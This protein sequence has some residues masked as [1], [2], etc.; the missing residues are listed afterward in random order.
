M[1][2]VNSLS[3]EVRARIVAALVEGVSISSIVRMTGVAK[4]TILR[5][6]REVG[7]ACAQFHDE[8]VRNLA[9]E[10][11]QADE[12]WS[13]CAMK[14]KNVP[15]EL[16][17]TIGIGSI[18]TWT[19][20]DADSRLIISWLASNRSPEAANA[21]LHDL[22]SR[23]SKHLQIS[24]DGLPHY[25]DAVMQSFTPGSASL[26]QVVKTYATSAPQPGMNPN[27]AASRYSPGRLL[28]IEKTS[29]LGT[30]DMKHVSTSYMERWNLTLRMGNRRF[31]R[32]TNA[33]SKKFEN[34][35][36]MLA[37]TVVFYNYCHA[38]KSLGGKTPAM[39]AGLT[40]YRWT[41]ADML[42]LDMWSEEKAA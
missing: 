35:C 14:Q 28:S 33:F 37:L 27:S 39:V 15:A 34:H 36:H 20:I 22:Q 24:S 17:E 21:L 18:W 38:H 5:L 8:Q 12:V 32:L 29:V 9:T 41:A 16:Q 23:T 6:L 13:F 30:P 11:V 3:P 7:T 26:G 25:I 2:C 31:T 42:R 4:T 40:D 10:R 1:L 19:A